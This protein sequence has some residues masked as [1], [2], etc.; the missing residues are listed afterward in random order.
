MVLKAR[1]GCEVEAEGDM[2]M[3]LFCPACRPEDLKGL[4][5]C[6]CGAAAVSF[7]ALEAHFLGEHL[8]VERPPALRVVA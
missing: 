4:F 5:I 7:E 1:C 3:V 6:E 8:G 2:A